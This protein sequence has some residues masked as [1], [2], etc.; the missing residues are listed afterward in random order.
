[1]TRHDR[2]DRQ[3]L[4]NL[5]GAHLL[6]FFLERPAGHDELPS[7]FPVLDDAKT[8]D[9]ADMH[10]RIALSHG[11]DLRVRTE[12][13]LPGDSDGVAALDLRFD[14]ALDGQARVKRIF[15]LAL[16]GRAALYAS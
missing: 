11:I 2:V 4:A 6:F 3:R 8:I 12:G 15:E 14:L 5:V 16:G 9:P 7:V 13:T 10:G 1:M